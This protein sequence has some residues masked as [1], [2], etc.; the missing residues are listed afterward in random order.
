MRRYTSHSRLAAEGSHSMPRR[1]PARLQAGAEFGV[2]F[3]AA[4]SV[5]GGSGEDARERWDVRRVVSGDGRRVHVH[6]AQVEEEC[7]ARRMR[8][9]TFRGAGAADVEALLFQG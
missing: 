8:S 2:H 4:S 9:M 5:R 7:G 1:R 3:G 6:P